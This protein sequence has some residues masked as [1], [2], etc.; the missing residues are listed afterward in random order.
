[1]AATP[2]TCPVWP[3]PSATAE[4]L[5]GA[6]QL[7]WHTRLAG[8]IERGLDQEPHDPAAAIAV[9]RRADAAASCPAS[10]PA[11]TGTASASVG[12]T[13]PSGVPGHASGT[14][15]A[16]PTYAPVT[17]WSLRRCCSTPTSRRRSCC[18][19]TPTKR[20]PRR[21]PEA[22]PPWC[23]SPTSSSSSGRC[24]GRAGGAVPGRAG[25]DRGRPGR[26]RAAVGRRRARGLPRG[27]R[28]PRRDRPRHARRA[29]RRQPAGLRIYA[30]YAGWEAGQLE[31][32]VEE[33]SWYVVPSLPPDCFRDDTHGLWRDVLRRQP[34]QLAWHSTRPLDPDLN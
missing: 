19:S 8:R 13:R 7:R 18:C 14:L 26:G 30:G 4:T 15:G 12:R 11:S 27:D 2:W 33:G 28:R 22:V 9:A 21:R 34:G 16:W 20:R 32:E 24:R 10:A 17:S 31:G 1:M 29:R 5:L 23:P 3:R 25:L 6:L